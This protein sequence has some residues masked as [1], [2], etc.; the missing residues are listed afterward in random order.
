[1]RQLRPLMFV[2]AST[3]ALH[4]CKE[5]I[6]EV[7][8]DEIGRTLPF[9]AVTG[10]SMGG[11]GAGFFAG[12]HHG[13]VDAVASLGGPLD[14]AWFLNRVERH[15][16]GGFCPYERLEALAQSNP[17]ALNDPAALDC[18][19]PESTKGYELPQ[20]FNHW[21]FTTNGGTFDRSAYQDLFWDLSLAMGNPLFHNPESPF[22]PVPELSRV[23]LDAALCDAPVVLKKF[24]N[25]EYNPEGK[26]DVIS[27]CDGEEPVLYC[28]DAD[29]TP[30]DYCSP[31]VSGEGGSP[32]AFCA[33]KGADKVLEAGKGSNQNPDLYYAKKGVFDPCYKHIEPVAFELAV[34]FNG[35]GRRDY[36]E[37]V[38]ANGHERFQDV[39]TDG[40]A[41]DREDGN[42]GCTA[43]GASGDPNK[44]DFDPSTNP[45][46]TEGDYVRQEGEPYADA[47]LDGVA[48]TG[49]FGEGN[50]IYD[51]SP[52]RKHWLEIDFRQNYLKAE[53]R[54]PY[55]VDVY[56]D[57]GYR[58]LFNFG[59]SAEVM[60]SGPRGLRPDETKSFTSY[61]DIPRVNGGTWEGGIFDALQADYAKM[62]RNVFVRY[63]NP[64]ATDREI[65]AGD[66]D[67]VGTPAQ[68]INRFG[69]YVKW[70]S[71]HWQPYFP[72][73]SAIQGM[74]RRTQVTYFSDR[75]GAK[76][77]YGLALPPGYDEP[78]NA[79]KKYPV[80]VL[81]HGYG[82]NAGGMSD[83][84]LIIDS[85][86]SHGD[87]IPM[88]FVYPSGRCCFT[89]PD[90]SADC[91]DEDDDGTPL[92]TKTNP[93]GSPM[94][95]RECRKGSFYVNRQG[96]KAGDNRMYGEALGEMM[97]QVGQN[98]RARPNETV[99]IKIP[100]P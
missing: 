91:R 33:S 10:V 54:L 53:S 20:D 11:I 71:N 63:G 24:Y 89:R 5:E 92:E 85:F 50:G 72:E 56:A 87:I 64:A 46:G 88:I 80:V 55:D 4:G 100:K 45:L 37:P 90:G 99:T 38:I 73:P 23:K 34:D 83:L 14:A 60:T 8:Y 32:E 47:G 76:V 81:G 43:T 58:D 94:Y 31:L 69:L 12:S 52:N 75:L 97:E 44:D 9:R 19:K 35:N 82:M 13:A 59:Y 21:R 36:H 78:A 25:A 74:S 84:N 70:L 98:Y 28:N 51:D 65:R 27:F 16:M 42:G 26:H 39:G 17:A 41:N 7:P 95:T 1:M 6:A 29:K 77:T 61:L 3:L 93:D 96:F 86:M 49:D 40:C 48:S 2:F 68:L 22:Y 30:V 15:Q 62:G 66:G 79:E 67:H 18:M 57:G